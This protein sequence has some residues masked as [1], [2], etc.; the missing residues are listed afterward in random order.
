[1]YA[2]SILTL[3]IILVSIWLTQDLFAQDLSSK[4]KA[5]LETLDPNLRQKAT[6]PFDHSERF[7]WHFIP[8]ER[9]G[10]NFHDLNP[11]QTEAGLQLLKASL[12]LPGQEK[13]QAIIELENVL[14]VVENRPPNDTYRDPD[15][16]F[17]SLFGTPDASGEWGWRFEGHHVSLNFSSKRGTIASATPTFFGSNPGIV[18]VDLHRGKQVLEK[19]TNLGFAFLES[20]DESQKAIAIYTDKAPNDILTGND[21]K[22]SLQSP[23]GI[24]YSQLTKSQQQMLEEL[25]AVYLINYTDS[26]R[27]RLWGKVRSTGIQHVHFAWAGSTVNAIGQPHYYRI[28]HPDL[29]IEYDNVQNNANHVHTVVRDLNNDFGEDVLGNHYSYGHSH[30]AE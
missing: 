6:F 5:F 2:K 23:K 26:V 1:M 14:R 4:A 7:N 17:F 24:G 25:I 16:Y 20:L 13:T 11:V 12:G 19:E 18:Q 28:Q 8:R 3:G 15:N 30:Q 22:A 29:L 27:D 10:V 21:R 9:K